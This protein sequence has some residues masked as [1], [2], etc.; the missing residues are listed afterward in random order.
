M[1][2]AYDFA[3]LP[4]RAPRTKP[5][6]FPDLPSLARRIHRDRL[7]QALQL[8]PDR[9]IVDGQVGPLSVIAIHAEDAAGNVTRFLGYAWLEGRGLD[10]L[11]GALDATLSPVARAA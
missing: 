3:L 5:A 1:P 2:V 6:V 4:D 10:A 11:K 8:R 9:V 7:G